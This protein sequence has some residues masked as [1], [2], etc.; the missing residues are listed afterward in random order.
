MHYQR[1]RK[2]GTTNEMQRYLFGM[3]TDHTDEIRQLGEINIALEEK[4]R[5]VAEL[6]HY[7]EVYAKA[8][9][10]AVAFAARR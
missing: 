4:R 9:I 5:Q 8:G 2:A 3:E 6:A 10:R 1:L 7:Q